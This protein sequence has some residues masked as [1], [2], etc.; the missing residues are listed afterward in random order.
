MKNILKYINIRSPADC[1][2]VML[3]FRWDIGEEVLGKIKRRNRDSR[4]SK[5]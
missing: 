5:R 1:I 3:C 2:L 4:I